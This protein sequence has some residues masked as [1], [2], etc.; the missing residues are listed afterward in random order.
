MLNLSNEDKKYL[1]R[2]ARQAIELALNHGDYH[3]F[4]DSAPAHLATPGASFVTLT[5]SGNLRGCIGTLKAYQ[6]LVQDVCEHAIAAALEDYRFS[7]VTRPELDE[8]EIEI[9]YL[10]EASR[11]SYNQHGELLQKIRRGED[12]VILKDGHRQ[13]TFLPQVWEQLP[14]HEEFLSHLCMKMGARKD[15]WKTHKLEVEVY[16]VYH[17]SENEFPRYTP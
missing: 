6:P 9:S 8:L 3:P 5:K 4:I 12:G 15:A 7:P 14:T 13:A 11:V 16:Q 2:A 1:L 17:F 10:T